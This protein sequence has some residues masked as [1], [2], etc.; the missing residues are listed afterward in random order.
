MF[1]RRLKIFLFMLLLATGALV[2]RAGQKQVLEHA[3]WDEL[4]VNAGK[5][6]PQLETRRG[7]IRD[8]KGVVI[9]ADEDCFDACVDYRALVTN[10]L[11][12]GVKARDRA[13]E[14]WVQG[15]ARSRLVAQ[16]GGAFT[17]APLDRR[18]EMLAAEVEAV[19][20]DLADMIPRLARMARV[21]ETTLEDARDAV[22]EKVRIR[23]R[24]LWY[25]SYERDLDRH[26]EEVSKAQTQPS[27]L[28]QKWLLEEDEEAPDLDS[29]Y[30]PI[31]EATAKHVLIRDLELDV[32]TELAKRIDRFPGLEIRPG[33]RR[34]YPLGAAAAHIIG[35]LAP[36]VIDDLKYDPN[37]NDDSRAYQH[38]DL[39]GS[40]GLEALCEPV[41]R[42]VRGKVEI[43]KGWEVGRVE[44]QPGQDVFASI[45]VELQSEVEE[46]FERVP[47][48]VP[49]QKDPDLIA[50]HGA[51]VVIDVA[52]GEV[53]VMASA[54]GFDPN[55]YDEKYAFHT[56][57]SN[58]D[59]P[60]LNR[61]TQAQREPGSTV[62]PIVGMAAV[63][64]GIRRADEGYE[65]TGYMVVNGR[66][67][68]DG[69]CWVTS[70]FHADICGPNCKVFPCP[71]VAHHQQ[72]S[73]AK[74]PTGWLTLADALERSC[75]PYFESIA[76]AMG[77]EKLSNWYRKFGLGTKT[78][79]GI[80][81]SSGLL[82]IDE[83]GEGPK[84]LSATFS[85]WLAG[86][87]Q[88]PMHATPLQMANVAATIARDGV[89][90][91]PK[92][93]RGKR[94]ES[95]RSA[96]LQ[97]PPTTHLAD[98]VDLGIPP[99]AVAAVR[100][101]MFRVV[102]TRAGS[103]EPARQTNVAVCGKTGTAQAAPV[104]VD[105]ID[106]K[107]GKPVP[108]MKDGKPVLDRK[109]RPKYMKTDLKISNPGDIN[110]DAKW[111]RG[112]GRE[113]GKSH[114]SWFMGY[115]PAENPQ[116]AFA[117]LVEYGGSGGAVAGSVAGDIV[118][119]CVAH[120]YLKTSPNP[121]AVA[122]PIAPPAEV[123][124]LR[125]VPATTTGPVN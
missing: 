45:D 125:D 18:K 79:I 96:Q 13:R 40:G 50:M 14:K 7:A 27:S 4:A 60:L 44:P 9:A 21:E 113:G 25:T 28:W 98:R 83:K 66:H 87:G 67:F 62:K 73:Y 5:R 76:H 8:V 61:A 64:S 17:D 111:Y 46:L 112:T 119:L 75:N 90:V 89:W 124:L 26:N 100:Q 107:T 123:E 58:L 37:K 103:G 59:R 117:V 39:K 35:R 115:A 105:L 29:F 6:S 22:V 74:H 114:H 65:C 41:L 110:P 70:M 106:P 95:D 33:N 122:S 48:K 82:P 43:V 68:E 15:H 88:G 53:R 77:P 12:N 97:L 55:R 36:V 38:T 11:K 71:N 34:I 91:R 78:Y 24:R 93:L 108:E 86:I 121:E 32:R 2:L 42:G 94:S 23:Q 1:E 69:R 56:H 54:P 99:A 63:A 51:A 81:E 10:P 118:K 3:K 80:A 104:R 116:I 120:G 109:G 31:S 102:H 30:V 85:T 49:G 16:L 92:L 19:N 72:P 57:P 47:I 52:T 20:A 101:G 84:G